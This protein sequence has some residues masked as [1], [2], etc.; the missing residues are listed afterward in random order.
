MALALKL[1]ILEDNPDDA[2][3]LLHELHRSGYAPDWERVETESDFRASLNDEIDLIVADYSL[4]AFGAVRAL[5]ILQEGNIDI[6]LIVVTGTVTEQVVVECLKLG[7]SDYLLKDRLTRLGGAIKRAIEERQL[8]EEKRAADEALRR[9]AAKLEQRVAERTAEL[10]RAKDS[11][12]V[13]LNHTSDAIVLISNAG[14]IQRVNPAFERLFGYQAD[15]VLDVPLMTLADDENQSVLAAAIETAHRVQEPGRVEITV[16]RRDETTF[17]ADIALAV[18]ADRNAFAGIVCSI[19]DISARKRIEEGLRQ[20]LEKERELSDLKSRFSSMVSHEFRTP[21]SVILSSSDLLRSYSDRMTPERRD[22]QLESIQQQVRRLVTMLDDILALGKAQTVGLD[23]TPVPIDVR[24]FCED[25]VVE[26]RPTATTHQFHFDASG[27]C[28]DTFA[29]VKLLRQ[30]ITNLLSNA[31]KY[32]PE[33]SSVY[34]RLSCEHEHILIKIQDEGSGIS[35]ED[36]QHLFEAFFRAKN[37]LSIPGSGLGLPIVKR[38][39]EAHGG[40]IVCESKLDQG[41][42]FTLSLPLVPSDTPA[43]D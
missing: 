41:T 36:Q 19:R 15:K 1:L 23:F 32:S 21:L 25:I 37:V 6:P 9:H 5:H 4:P 20:A 42:T 35:Q 10:Q 31:I 11:V 33:G 38:A 22:Q 14:F 26:L 39:I 27:D 30:A 16:Q 43:T 34:I 29:D 24:D 12:E 7:A 2:E 3:V 13:I 17:V 28:Y 8:R 18:M 40:A